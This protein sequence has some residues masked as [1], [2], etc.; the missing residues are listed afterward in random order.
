[1]RPLRFLVM[2][3]LLSGCAGTHVDPS[4]PAADRA[5]LKFLTINVWSGLT[6][7]GYLRMGEYETAEGRNTRHEILIRQIRELD[8]DVVAIQEANKL[9]GYVS[10]LAEE[11]DYAAF[12]HV[13]LGGIRLGKVGLPWNLR[14]GDAILAKKDLH[15]EFAGR[16]QLSGGP[17]GNSVTFHFEDA[18]QIV[19]VRLQLRGRP[20]Y[21]FT[22]HWHASPSQDQE[23]EQRIIEYM[24]TEDVGKRKINKYKDS[25]LAGQAW[26]MSE[27]EKT[28]A[29]IRRTAGHHPFVLM[30]DL[31]A[32][33][34]SEEIN[35][36]L[37]SGM[38]DVYAELNVDSAGFTWNP[39][40]NTNI[41]RH[42]LSR[43][44]QKSR[45]LFSRIITIDQAT[46]KRIDY[47]L[48][49]PAILWDQGIVN[50]IS[51]SVT[52]DKVLRGTHAS[53]HFGVL[54]EIEFYPED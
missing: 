18:T 29:F 13:G 8:P 43:S 1:M 47:I 38:K 30:G 3:F 54:A 5:K 34:R 45:G 48:A 50:P 10:D 39:E 23:T 42:Y 24:E 11:L 53:D 2:T 49:G 16:R 19:G 6:Y 46:P 51:C 41:Q 17:V 26:R 40:Q 25:V 28:V 32:L 31:N 35:L 22:T 36:L 4:P 20:I 12:Y 33:A 7:Q 14:E 52:M 37:E 44:T 9:P 21:V 15:P 27:A